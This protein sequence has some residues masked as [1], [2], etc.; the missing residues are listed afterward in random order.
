MVFPLYEVNYIYLPHMV[1]SLFAVT[2]L[3]TLDGIFTPCSDYD[4]VPHMVLTLY[5][6]IYDYLP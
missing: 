5:A 1:F 6:V 4:Y 3:F 2:W